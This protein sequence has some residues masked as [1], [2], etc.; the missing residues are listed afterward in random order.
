MTAAAETAPSQADATLENFLAAPTHAVLLTAQPGTDLAAAATGVASRLL[1]V[2]GLDNHAYY[3]AVLPDAGKGSLLIEQIRELLAFF[4]LKVP[5]NAAVKRIAVL[6]DAHTM[7]GEAQN[8]LL[9]LLEEPPDGSVL[10]LTSTRPQRLL[11]TIRSRV[12]TIHLPS[13][14]PAPEAEA[15]Q[16]VRQVLASTT[17]DRLLLV[18]SL[19]KQKDLAATF[20]S[21]LATV[22]IASLEAA[23]R[24][25]S[26]SL[27]RWQTV[28]QAAASAED[29]L[30]HSGNTKLVLTELMLAM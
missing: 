16:L 4:R 13:S 20:V 6:Q 10:I 15:V 14:A 29:A 9:K 3:R 24:K 25:G 17:Y 19:A 30:M 22:A 23:A 28:L 21:T 2:Q 26:S 27:T 18:E 1:G 11:A 7:T 5:G 12:Q 8:A